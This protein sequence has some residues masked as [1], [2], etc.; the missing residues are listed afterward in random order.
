MHDQNK[1]PS[2][3][4]ACFWAGKASEVESRYS[5]AHSPP[6]RREAGIWGVR[7]NKCINFGYRF[8]LGFEQQHYYIAIDPSYIPKLGKPTSKK[9]AKIV[10]EPFTIAAPAA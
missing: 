9:N 8:E 5:K 6:T 1:M 4:L 10:K 7:K 3:L 2:I